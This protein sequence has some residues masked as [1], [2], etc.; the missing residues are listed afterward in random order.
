M[1]RMGEWVL[2]QEEKGNIEFNDLRGV[3]VDTGR[4]SLLEQKERLEWEIKGLRSDLIVI[5]SKLSRLDSKR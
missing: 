4:V 5:K 3:Y 1:S 2:D